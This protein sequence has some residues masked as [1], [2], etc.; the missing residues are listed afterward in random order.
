VE[1]EIFGP[2]AILNAENG[3]SIISQRKRK[4]KRNNR[5]KITREPILAG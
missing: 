2:F 4:R 1:K 3:K 5:D